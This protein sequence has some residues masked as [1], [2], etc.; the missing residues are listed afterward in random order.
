MADAVA[1]LAV[2]VVDRAHRDFSRPGRAIGAG[3]RDRV[4]AR[5]CGLAYEQARVQEA[6]PARVGTVCDGDRRQDDPQ[7][8]VGDSAGP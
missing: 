2:Q 7:S 8:S 4:G 3:R 6:A 1:G 5:S